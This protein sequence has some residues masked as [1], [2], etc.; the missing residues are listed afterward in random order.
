MITFADLKKYHYHYWLCFPSFKLT[1]PIKIQT[2][3]FVNTE[4]IELLKNVK[5][6][7]FFLLKNEEYLPFSHLKNVDNFEGLTICFH[8]HAAPET[9]PDGAV[10]VLA[11]NL[12]SFLW[13]KFGTNSGLNFNLLAIRKSFKEGKAILEKSKF[14]HISISEDTEE[15]Y[16]GGW[17]V[18]KGKLTSKKIDLSSQMDPKVLVYKSA[19]FNRQW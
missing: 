1:K 10:G 12:L 14:F 5:N 2:E 16:G 17:E 4:E 9:T 3:R 19:I 15:T 18:Y 8:D 6:E 7:K 13:A 11:R